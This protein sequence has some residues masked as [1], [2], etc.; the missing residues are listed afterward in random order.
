[1][2]IKIPD[3]KF[4]AAIAGMIGISLIITMIILTAEATDEYGLPSIDNYNAMIVVGFL[5]V[6]LSITTFGTLIY[7]AISDNNKTTEETN[8]EDAP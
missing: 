2:Y 4:F 6:T 1:M 5:L 8:E 7:K 3:T